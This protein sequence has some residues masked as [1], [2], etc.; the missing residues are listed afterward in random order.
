MNERYQYWPDG[1]GGYFVL[2]E[3]FQVVGQVPGNMTPLRTAPWYQPTFDQQVRNMSWYPTAHSLMAWPGG[4]GGVQEVQDPYGGEPQYSVPSR[5]VN[6]NFYP[7]SGPELV[8]PVLPPA[9]LRLHDLFLQDL[10]RPGERPSWETRPLVTP[11]PGIS[12]GGKTFNS[13]DHLNNHLLHR[14]PINQEPVP[15]WNM[16]EELPTKNEQGLPVPDL[17]PVQDQ[18]P[19]I[20]PELPPP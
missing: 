19:T 18:G 16:E 7:Y 17:P 6:P 11:S 5:G 15:R 14:E 10:N 1:R 8:A 13:I 3:N 4:I 2:N 9:A 20:V 12:Y